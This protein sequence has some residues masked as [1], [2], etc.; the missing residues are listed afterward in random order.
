V[1]EGAFFDQVEKVSVVEGIFHNLEKTGA[2]FRTVAVADSFH[3]QLSERAVVESDFAENV[4]D[5]AAESFAL[6]A[7]FLEEPIIDGALAGFRSDQI[8]EVADLGLTDA[9]DPAEAL[10]D[11]IGVPRQVVI[12][13]QMGALEI[14]TLPGGVGGDED[15]HVFVLR[16]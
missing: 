11:A 4:E 10:F 14:D 5:L 6:L 12:D 13:H 16:E 1:S 2:N 7:E 8:P 3:E 15:L 9:V